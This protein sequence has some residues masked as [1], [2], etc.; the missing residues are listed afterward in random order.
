VL[1]RIVAMRNSAIA[2]ADPV[3]DAATAHEALR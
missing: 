2:F 3:R 1:H